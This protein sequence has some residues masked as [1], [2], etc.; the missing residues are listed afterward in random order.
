ML[1]R[2]TSSQYAD[3]MSSLGGYCADYNQDGKTN[4][5]DAAAIAAFLASQ[6]R[7]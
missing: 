2:K 5:R 7:H 1:A 4:V 6:Y 3:F